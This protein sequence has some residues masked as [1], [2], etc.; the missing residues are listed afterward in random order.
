MLKDK[1]EKIQKTRLGYMETS[2]GA[3]KFCGQIATIEVPEEWSA[4]MRDELATELCDCYEA[5][6]YQ[7]RKKR[8]EKAIDA[9]GEQ[10]GPQSK[11]PAGERIMQLMKESVDLIVEELLNS[12][13][14]DIGCGVKAKLGTTAKGNIKVEKTITE[15]TTKEA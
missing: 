8:K 1:I 15:K 7:H 10:F 2:H 11:H 3:C 6:V 14:V 5:T 4:E 12:V 9:L 13:T